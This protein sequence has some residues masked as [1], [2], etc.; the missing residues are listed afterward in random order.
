M[1]YMRY[2]I[3]DMNKFNLWYQQFK[4]LISSNQFLILQNQIIDNITFKI[5]LNSVY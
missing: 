3:T 2:S 1:S 5:S 4:F